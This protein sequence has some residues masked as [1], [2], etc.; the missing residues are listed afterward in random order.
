[1]ALT[2]IYFTTEG[3]E[4]TE[5]HGDDVS[6]HLLRGHSAVFVEISPAFAVWPTPS[7][8]ELHRS[9]MVG[10]VAPLGDD[11]TT[12]FTALPLQQWGEFCDNGWFRELDRD[13]GRRPLVAGMLAANG[14]CACPRA[15]AR[16]VWAGDLA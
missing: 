6:A 15:A 12:H 2:S 10:G 11:V 3:T 7:R 5:A 14:R 1:M 13:A 9:G 4:N 16:P 8:R